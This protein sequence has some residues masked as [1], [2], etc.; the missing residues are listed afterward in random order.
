MDRNKKKEP[1]KLADAIF[2]S[3]FFSFFKDSQEAYGDERKFWLFILQLL[4][5]VVFTVI[6]FILGFWLAV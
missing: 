5:G 2:T 3:G 4:F 1:W 6:L